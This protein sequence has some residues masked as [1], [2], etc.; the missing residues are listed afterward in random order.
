M[1]LLTVTGTEVVTVMAVAVT[2]LTATLAADPDIRRTITTTDIGPLVTCTIDHLQRL[3]I[4]PKTLTMTEVT[5]PV[6]HKME[7]TVAIDFLFNIFSLV[8]LKW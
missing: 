6:R 5:L 3:P 2:V 1:V 4:R 7:I 8:C